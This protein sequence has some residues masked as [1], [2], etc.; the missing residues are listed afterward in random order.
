M[1]EDATSVECAA[2]L[3]DVMGGFVVPPACYEM[4][5]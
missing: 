5:L 3:S 2:L 4:T 1:W